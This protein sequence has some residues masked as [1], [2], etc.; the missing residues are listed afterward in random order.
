MPD[1]PFDL[2]YYVVARGTDFAQMLGAGK[3]GSVW[4]TVD[5]AAVKIHSVREVYFRELRCYERL[6]D[7]NVHDVL[8]LSVPELLG[9][10]DQ[11]L[12]IE[13]TV[14]SPPFLLDFASAYLDTPPDFP[15]EV[16]AQWH[17][18]L[19]GRFGERYTDALAVFDEL[20][21]VAGVYLYDVH[22]DNLKFER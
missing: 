20:K 8:G 9:N 11:R 3:D 22:A 13:M 5:G 21:R 10:D 12:V 6:A 15:P 19:Q 1:P 2:E 17:E 14:V 4:K 18:D 16:L 7:R